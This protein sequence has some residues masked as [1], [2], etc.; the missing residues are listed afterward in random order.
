M[1]HTAG[2][3]F[4]TQYARLRGEMFVAQINVAWFLGRAAI[5]TNV[6]SHSLLL[7]AAWSRWEEWM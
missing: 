1:R 7:A 4:F 2:S 6:A 3:R 5:A